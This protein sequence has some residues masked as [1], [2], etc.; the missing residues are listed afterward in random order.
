VASVPARIDP[1]SA[2]S[3]SGARLQREISLPMLVLYGLGTTIGAGIYALTGEVAGNAGFKA[4]LSFLIAAALA[5]ITGLGFAELA[6]RLPK[7][8]GEAVFVNHAFRRRRLTQAV[9]IA[10]LSAGVVSAAAISNAFGGYISELT[11]ISETILVVGLVL[12]LGAVAVTGAKESVGTAAVFTA[13]EIVGLGLVVWAGRNALAD[14]PERAGDL[15]G[16]AVGVDAWAGIL[17]GS[18]LAFFAFLGFE[19]IDAVA[20]ETNDARVTLPRAILVTLGLTTFLYLAVSAVAVL[21]VHPDVLGDSDAPL[22]LVYEQAGGNEDLLSVIAG[23]AMVNGALVQLVMIPRVV[24]GLAN[25]G[26][27][28][29]TIGAVSARTHV[30]VRATLA[31]LVVVLALAVSLELAPLARITST[32]TLAVFVAINIALIAIKRRDGATTSFQVPFWLPF[33]GVSAAGLLFVAEAART[34]GWT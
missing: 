5:G 25:L 11:G 3:E 13:I 2:G 34:L 22:A 10:V 31:G 8:A 28:P 16:P 29:K 19:D 27:V 6:G 17:A 30:P 33:V 14:V 18:F 9:G 7:A 1:A 24:Y 15:L 21:N 32:A 20:E 23:L 4:P 12:A 26:L